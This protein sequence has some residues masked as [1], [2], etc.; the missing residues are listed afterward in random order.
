MKRLWGAT[1]AVIATMLLAGCGSEAE[2]DTTPSLT[3]E[4]RGTPVEE[5]PPAGSEAEVGE[6]AEVDV[7]PWGPGTFQAYAPS[8]GALT[9]EIPATE[10]PAD[11]EVAR[12]AVGASP[13]IYVTVDVDNR[14]GQQIVNMYEVNL[15][16]PDGKEYKFRN[17]STVI[18]E[19]Y[20]DVGV[21]TAEEID[22]YNL[23]VETANNYRDTVAISQRA[24]MVL[25]GDAIP[26]QI[27]DIQVYAEGAFE[28]T[29]A[30]PIA[31]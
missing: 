30:A 11:I 9:L 1:A 22:L 16:D 20:S 2:P 13:V 23:G 24:T 7:G 12:E 18:D 10:A 17:A 6:D 4:T 31:P 15:Y 21:E 29:F 8:G 26:D 19:W 5:E 14:E 3:A 28:A 25:I 27:A